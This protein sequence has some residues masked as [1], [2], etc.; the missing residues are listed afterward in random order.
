MATHTHT[1][2]PKTFSSTKTYAHSTGL[3][4]CFRQWRAK[5]HCHFLH[6]YALKVELVFTGILD[7]R[8]WVQD[9]GGLKEVK[10][11]LEHMFDHTTIVAEDDPALQSFQTLEMAGLVQLRIVKDVG[12]E[13][14]AELIMDKVVEMGFHNLQSVRIWEH[15]GN[16][17]IV[18]R[19]IL[20]DT[21]F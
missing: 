3:S 7:E 13:R 20:I 8:N 19:K 5:S 17:A 18:S 2:T 16:S 6:G 10:K 4:C 1:Q 15:E 11:W 21:K 9:F 12:C 14:F